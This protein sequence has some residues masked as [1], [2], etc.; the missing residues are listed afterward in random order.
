M[1]QKLSFRTQTSNGAGGAPR[2][3][4]NGGYQVGTTDLRDDGWHHVVAVF[5]EGVDNVND[6]LLYVDGSLQVNSATLGQAL[7]T[8]VG[9]DV[10]LGRDF[11]AAN[12]WLGALDDMRIYNAALDAGA[13]AD[14]FNFVAPPTMDLT[15]V[16][17]AVEDD[18]TFT[19]GVGGLT[20]VG[21]LTI[22]DAKTLT[23]GG[24]G[25][26][27][28][29]S[30]A[31]GGTSASIT[32]NTLTRLGT[33]DDGGAAV[34]ITVNGTS[35][36]I[37]DNGTA[38][39][40]GAGSTFNVAGG[41]LVVAA[42]SN[43]L[44]GASVVL[45][46]GALALTDMTG[47]AGDA[48][49]ITLD[50]ALDV[51]ADSTLIAGR[52]GD[53]LAGPKTIVL[54]SAANGLTITSG[55]LGVR[56][57]DDYTLNLNGPI[58][59]A[60]RIEFLGGTVAVT[61]TGNTLGQVAAKSGANVV[62]LGSNIVATER[63]E[64]SPVLTIAADLGAGADSAAAVWI[65]A[66]NAVDGTVSLTGN[67]AYT[68]ETRI[69]RGV[70]RADEGAGLPTD[71]GIEFASTGN[72]NLAVLATSGTLTRT[73][74]DT[75][76]TPAAAGQISW[77]AGRGGFAAEG[78]D[79]TVTLTGTA[80][81]LTWGSLDNG[82]AGQTIQFGSPDTDGVVTL[83]SNID[84]DGAANRLIQVY[85][86]STTKLTGAISGGATSNEFRL[87]DAGGSGAFGGRLILD[88]VATNTFVSRFELNEGFLRTA[89]D[90]PV[91]GLSPDARLEFEANSNARPAILESNGTFSRTIG[92][93]AGNVQWQGNGGG[94]AAVGGPLTVSL[95]N[96]EVDEQLVW[97]N[98][99]TGFNGKWLMFGSP[100]ADDAVTLTNG[101]SGGNGNRNIRVFD[102][103]D[104]AAD[105]AILAGV[106]HNFRTMAVA[107]DGTLVIANSVKID[108]GGGTGYDFNIN[109]SA[110]VIVNGLL[111]LMDDM[112]VQGDG[113]TL[114][115]IGVINQHTIAGTT[116]R[117]NIQ[118]GENIAPGTLVGMINGV[119]TL[120]FEQDAGDELYLSTDSIYQWEIDDTG[121]NDTVAVTGLAGGA[122]V[123]RDQW[124]INVN[125]L[126]IGLVLPTTEYVL[127][128]LNE[129]IGLTE[130][131]TARIGDGAITNFLATAP[132]GWDLRD[133]AVR[134]ADIGNAGG[135]PRVYMTGLAKLPLLESFQ[136]GTWGDEAS[137]DGDP[138]QTPE[139]ASDTRV[140]GGHTITVAA[141]G[142]TQVLEIQDTASV[143]V[144][145]G[146][147]LGG[148]PIYRVD[149]LAGGGLTVQG[150][151]AAN[152]T[153]VNT[154]GDLTVE[155]A[156]TLNA[157][158]VNSAGTTQFQSGSLGAIGTL[159]VT[160]GTA[161]ISSPAITTI[162]ASGG[163]L[164][165]GASVIDLN[166][167][168]GATVN[169]TAAV[170]VTNVVVSDG[171]MMTLGGAMG[172][173]GKLVVHGTAIQAGV[174]AVT[175]AE[176]AAIDFGS[177]T[178]KGTYTATA[179]S[180]QASGAI[181][182][183]GA[184]NI[185]LGGAG[186]VL[187]VNA[188]AGITFG[189]QSMNNDT[190][191]T[192]PAGGSLASNAPSYSLTASGG[193]I[194]NT[195]DQGY[196]AYQA[197]DGTQPF[198]VWGLV[199]PVADGEL[200]GFVGG[201]NAWKK[202]GL[203]VRDSLNDNSRNIFVLVPELDANGINIQMRSVDGGASI[204][205]STN[206]AAGT[207]TG[208]RVP[209]AEGVFL[210]LVYA[211]DGL[212]LDAYYSDSL[213]PDPS[214]ASGDWILINDPVWDTVGNVTSPLNLGASM[215]GD[216]SDTIYVGLALTSH[217][218]A[219][220]TTAAFEQLNGFALDAVPSFNNLSGEGTI[221][222]GA[223]ISGQVSPGASPGVIVI[224]GDATFDATS[225]YLWQIGDRIDVLDGDLTL[226][227]GQLIIDELTLVEAYTLMTFE[228]GRLM[229][230]FDP[231]T[232][233]PDG[234][235]VEYDNA[236]GEI[237][238]V[239]EPATLALL[240]LGSMAAIRR[241]R[242]S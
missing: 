120:T 37:L 48:G 2:V 86:G 108:N 113:S 11:N 200:S 27:S 72:T 203:M 175:I 168:G 4:I 141:T 164:N 205:G 34:T 103:P 49:S 237:R 213:T 15:G 220:Q 195:A 112:N 84:L 229:G 54:G 233:L 177:G 70:L 165:T 221:V 236:G 118:P 8:A 81:P 76:L 82:F 169:T 92:T 182:N 238:V 114:G 159:N 185:V 122:L 28:F 242:R 127:F 166:V 137:W 95:I 228:P 80:D 18:S 109:E 5:P 217:S 57:S 144:A 199:A 85:S 77:A 223:A 186:S 181:S 239:P 178:Y 55:T 148:A 176:G 32:A 149:V 51:L 145:D 130:H 87:N 71:G 171:G 211:G 91:V 64:F 136:S 68:G 128:D 147:V 97:G 184:E 69:V 234:Y 94:F 202:A 129:F 73:I 115:G 66:D 133:M 74:A 24:S 215:V 231:A 193:D 206:P 196:F 93:A 104:T 56:T 107:G 31:F 89:V 160:G 10:R 151:G 100:E 121:A 210:R 13:V 180:F 161:T 170:T 226:L 132:A 163:V 50:S 29:A 209:H 116:S 62:G 232:A 192:F 183:A 162:N 134:F 158:T 60:G 105:Y 204:S 224:D 36:L 26:V 187:T 44:D 111:G 35:S 83:T 33:I 101:I 65:G 6:I 138:G 45:S 7:N 235:S 135:D 241:R 110:T 139:A 124:N 216:G 173:D 58:S 25:P 14:L 208:M 123:L 78:G 12:D 59:G 79:L 143:V 131:A 20:S 227:G 126:G 17:V 16:T 3:E 230:Q 214:L 53:G 146:G 174:N 157:A 207:K 172:I 153:T 240:F 198:D 90:G 88:P 38:N 225:T 142:E 39:T 52:F 47:T 190:N 156:G 140:L 125:D 188:S 42:S 106:L 61:S 189:G 99:T 46:G 41:Q 75:T 117:V 63:Y 119:G 194:Y 9:A 98:G 40:L 19:T 155:S 154:A 22:A 201:T 102:N 43:P 30:T 191:G 96:G 179:G 197:F 152:A 218:T 67:N 1:S 150:G 21:L 212:G 222:G 219:E 23:T 167:L